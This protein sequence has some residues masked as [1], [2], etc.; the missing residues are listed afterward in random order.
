MSFRRVF[1][2]PLSSVVL[3]RERSPAR[4]LFNCALAHSPVLDA[5]HRASVTS[6]TGRFGWCFRLKARLLSEKWNNKVNTTENIDNKCVV[7]VSSTQDK[8]LLAVLFVLI[9]PFPYSR[10]PPP[11]FPVI[12]WWCERRHERFDWNRSLGDVTKTA[13]TFLSRD[14][15]SVDRRRS[16]CVTIT[17]FDVV[18]SLYFV[19]R[20]RKRVAI[21]VLTCWRL[22]TVAYLQ[23]FLCR[24]HL[25]EIT[26]LHFFLSYIA[27]GASFR[28]GQNYL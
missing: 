8:T 10:S 15:C 6:Q 16:D 24:H 9:P 25:K 28:L 12:A 2:R 5:W 18:S 7:C 11:H 1:A 13:E 22:A 19:K 14:C 17:V 23:Q 26:F 21:P 27:L 4:P 20:C 3:P